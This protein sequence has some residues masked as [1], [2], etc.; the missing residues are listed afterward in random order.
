M[1]QTTGIFAILIYGISFLALTD[2][3]KAQNGAQ[4]GEWRAYGGDKG[5]TKYSPLDQI[6]QD[7]FSELEIAWRMKSPDAFLS[8]T[9]ENGSELTSSL[10]N[11][12]EYLES[13]SPN[14]Y[15]KQNSPRYS[16]MQATPLMIDGVLYFNTA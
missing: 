13:E 5:S 1:K 3:T 15:R 9:T 12:V 7:N 2:P 11:V 6:D 10:S 14:L 16:Q 4:D 8:T